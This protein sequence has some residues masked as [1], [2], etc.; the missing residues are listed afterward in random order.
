MSLEAS[1]T[2]ALTWPSTRVSTSAFENSSENAKPAVPSG[3]VPASDSASDSISPMAMTLAV[4]PWTKAPCS[5]VVLA[6][7]VVLLT[8]SDAAKPEPVASCLVSVFIAALAPAVEI[9]TAALPAVT[10]ASV[11]SVIEALAVASA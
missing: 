7:T 1:P 9:S 3:L 10:D 6:V 4:L 2:F 8:A 11:L 5:T